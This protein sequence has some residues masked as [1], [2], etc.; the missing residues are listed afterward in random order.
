M[1]TASAGS[2][3]PHLRVSAAVVLLLVVSFNF[4]MAGIW[5]P[6]RILKVTDPD[7]EELLERELYLS[8]GEASES[9][10]V[11]ENV[12][13]GSEHDSNSEQ[14]EY[15]ESDS[16]PS[17][18]DVRP[19]P[20]S[21]PGTSEEAGSS[22]ETSDEESVNQTSRKSKFFRGRNRFKWSKVP[23]SIVGKTRQ[24]NITMHLPGPRREAKDLGNKPQPIEIWQLFFSDLMIQRIIHWTNMHISIYRSKW[25]NQKR[26]ELQNVDLV[27]M[28]AF[29]GLILLTSITKSG[30]ESLRSL[31]NTKGYGRDVF[32]ATMSEKRF[33]TL[34][35]CL[36]FDDKQT[37][38]ERARDDPCAAISEIFYEFIEH[39]QRLYC[40]GDN[41]C[42]D[43]MLVPFR[44]RCKFKVYMPNKPAKYG[45]KI[46]CLTDGRTN[47]LYNAYLYGGKGT[48][49]HTLTQNEKKLSIPTQ[50]VIR[51]TKPIEKTNRNITADNWFSSIE[52]V[53][54][55][56]KRGLTYVGTVRKV[57][58]EIPPEFQASRQRAVGTSLFGFTKDITLVSYVLKKSKAVLLVSSTHHDRKCDEH[59]G[60]PDIILYYNMYKSGVDTLDQQCSN[61]SSN[62]RTR[63][64]PMAIFIICWTLVLLTVL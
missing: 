43:E 26:P 58:K 14:S 23:P 33:F 32:R 63:R 56:K 19:V 27:E 11:D 57:K 29:L 55:L 13:V 31:F 47:Y 35:L 3:R 17:S 40:I 38:E 44:G 15:F 16:E 34:L 49:S 53:M 5:R 60:K 59:S 45:L 42:I 21:R 1:F 25:K 50:S 61:Y 8:D 7:C 37:R 54:E 4:E 22:E 30:H 64:W 52:L 12:F 51:L 62:R 24:H 20:V 46:M 6:G 39:C 2:V 28:K 10:N 36:R 41:R 18:L 48:D 9:E